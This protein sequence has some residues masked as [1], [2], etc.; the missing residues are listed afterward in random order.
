MAFFSALQVFIVL[1]RTF[2]T[3]PNSFSSPGCL[4]YTFQALENKDTGSPSLIHIVINVN[5][6]MNLFTRSRCR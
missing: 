4:Q 1:R 2:N 6:S 3:I 5:V